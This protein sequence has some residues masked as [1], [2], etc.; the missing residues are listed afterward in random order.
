MDHTLS[1]LEIKLLKEIAKA[2]DSGLYVKAPRGNYTRVNRALCLE[3]D[4]YVDSHYRRNE[5]FFVINNEGRAILGIAPVII[6]DE[7]APDSE[8]LG[9][10]LPAYQDIPAVNQFQEELLKLVGSH[11][12][13]SP[14]I[15]ATV[16]ISG[17]GMEL[18][19]MGLLTK[20]DN[21][22]FY[23]VSL[24]ELGMRTLI[25]I[26]EVTGHECSKCGTR[27]QSPDY[28]CCP[29][30]DI[31]HPFEEPVSLIMDT[32]Y[33]PPTGPALSPI[34]RA[35]L[36]TFDPE[37]CYLGMSP[38]V[39]CTCKEH[40]QG[41]E[42]ATLKARVN[43]LEER[44]VRMEKQTAK[45]REFVRDMCGYSFNDRDDARFVSDCVDELERDS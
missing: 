15:R 35:A 37:F 14:R 40:A 4:G 29:R 42:I 19:E 22:G 26:N 17:G 24:T 7:D 33:Q 23:E 3:S 9:D 38:I 34:E 28:T 32:Y 25:R 16:F 20:I 31:E 8:T 12:E 6:E 44:D 21:P 13:A 5:Q 1:T 27:W 18:V 43:A 30:C 39:E 36:D 41:R 2:G 45:H 10:E 11:N